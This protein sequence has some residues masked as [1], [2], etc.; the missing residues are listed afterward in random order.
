MIDELKKTE[1]WQ[2]LSTN[3]K[4]MEEFDKYLKD[5]MYNVDISDLVYEI[6]DNRLV[7][8]YNSN[9]KN[10]D[11]D[12][13]YKVFDKIEF[14]LDEEGNIIINKLS[15]KLESNYGYDFLTTNG[16]VINTHYSCQVFDENGIELDY[17]SYRDKYHIDSDEFDALESDLK[18]VTE[19]QYNPNLASYANVTGVYPRA[20]LIGRGAK[21]IRQIRSKDNLGI[22]EMTR[23]SLTPD[24][25]I[26][27]IKEEYYFNTF[28]TSAAKNN[29]ELIHIINGFP[30]A[31][32]VNNDIKINDDYVYLGLTPLNYREVAKD[33]FLKELQE[34]KNDYKM[35]KDVSAKYDLM[36]DLMSNGIN[37]KKNKH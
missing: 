30:F 12:C 24:S 31:N 33:R 26:S 23:C 28:Y 5:S 18:S 8:C 17:Q 1:L 6:G 13:Q 25:R 16:G 35:N 32:I 29:P 34:S 4:F 19:T 9:V 14:Y 10:R 36:I 7:A 11:L 15:G 2:E 21:Y 20:N 27:D 37:V 3:K 22:V